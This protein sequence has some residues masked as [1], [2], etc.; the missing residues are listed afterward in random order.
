M[1]PKTLIFIPTYD[2]RDNVRPMCEQIFALGLDADLLFLDDASPDGTGKIL[3]AMAAQRPRM[4]VIH[5]GGKFGIGGAHLE[6]IALAYAEAY[7]RL[8]T[9]DCD[10]THSPALIP[11]FLK[12]AN[13]ADVVVGS[14]YVRHQSLPGW[15][16][17]RRILTGVEI[18]VR[19]DATFE[20]PGGLRAVLVVPVVVSTTKSRL[21]G[22][23]PTSAKTPMAGNDTNRRRADARAEGGAV[24]I[25]RLVPPP[26]E[27]CSPRKSRD[28]RVAKW[29]GRGR[30]WAAIP[31]WSWCRPCCRSRSR[32]RA[33][34][35]TW[36]ARAAKVR[37][38][39]R[40]QVE[41]L[42]PRGRGRGLVALAERGF[43][44]KSRA[45]RGGDKIM[46]LRVTA[47]RNLRMSVS[48]RF[49]R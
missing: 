16:R 35:G 41:L 21:R 49:C 31:G 42:P 46:V 3:D 44:E 45:R 27:G 1:A 26:P 32:C 15:S 48:S 4:R 22:K 18:E 24:G 13:T 20:D 2:E 47:T 7:Q 23:A 8:V 11:T 10:F 33:A 37:T 34:D 43:D 5:R 29:V 9:L 6:G 28:R 40:F 30:A 17:A 14:R 25:S 38:L 19:A 36:I 12:R 39:G